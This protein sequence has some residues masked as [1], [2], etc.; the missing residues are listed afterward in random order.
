MFTWFANLK[1]AWKLGI[2][3]IIFLIGFAAGVEIT[4]LVYKAEQIDQLKADIKVKNET[5]EAQQKATAAAATE[6]RNQAANVGELQR[7]LG[8]A[9]SSLEDLN[10]QI[11]ALNAKDTSYKC[12]ITPNGLQQINRIFG[13]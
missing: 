3:G 1:L 13:N 7:K 8:V 9:N 4:R 5:I 11:E 10:Q 2:L 12:V 6:A